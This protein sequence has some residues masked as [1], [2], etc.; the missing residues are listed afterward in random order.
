MT[1]ADR[2]ARC[3]RISFV[4]NDLTARGDGLFGEVCKTS[5]SSKIAYGD[6]DPSRTSN[7]KRLQDLRANRG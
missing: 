3:I 6:L 2:F 7:L 4:R 1:H 5:E